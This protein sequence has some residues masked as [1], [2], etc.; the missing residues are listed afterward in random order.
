MPSNLFLHYTHEINT[1]PLLINPKFNVKLT[2]Q[3]TTVSQ[4]DP[5]KIE[6]N[7]SIMQRQMEIDR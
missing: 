1:H 2:E 6:T 3:K 4:L 5:E 7:E